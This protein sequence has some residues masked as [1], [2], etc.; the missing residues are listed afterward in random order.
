MMQ[1]LLMNVPFSPINFQLLCITIAQLLAILITS[2]ICLHAALL[3]KFESVSTKYDTALT[4][5]GTST[6]ISLVTLILITGTYEHSRYCRGLYKPVLY[7]GY[8][9]YNYWIMFSAFYWIVGM[10]ALS[11]SFEY[12]HSLLITS[13]TLV[14]WTLAQIVIY[15]MN[16]E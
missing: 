4:F 3:M 12:N 10:F 9:G 7:T 5:L 15:Y 14:G 1:D 2:S 11:T 6:W 16:R 8:F 13:I